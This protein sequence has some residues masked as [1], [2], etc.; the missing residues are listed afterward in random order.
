M[1]NGCGH[2]R[3]GSIYYNASHYPPGGDRLTM[4]QDLMLYFI[5]SLVSLISVVNPLLAVPVFTALTQ[6]S[7]AR[8][9]RSLSRKAAT[10]V[11]FVLVLFFVSG[12]FILNFFGISIEALRIAGGVMILTSAFGMLNKEDRLLPEEHAE[13]AEKDDWAFSPLAMPLMSGPGAIAV[14]MGMTADATSLTHYPIIFVVV[15]LASL[16]CYG[17]L[18]GSHVLVERLG[19]TLMKSFTRIMGFILLCV[20]IQFMVNGIQGVVVPWLTMAQ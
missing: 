6:T 7:S 19:Q 9:R 17:V 10:N 18:L 16:A 20:G 15:L 2:N 13:C 8:E 4:A 11:F 14:I 3:S 1:C 12:H 5:G